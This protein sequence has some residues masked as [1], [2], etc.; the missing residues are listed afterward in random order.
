M[1]VTLKMEEM[2]QYKEDLDIARTCIF[3]MDKN[4]FLEKVI[5]ISLSENIESG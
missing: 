2:Y 3:S 4:E 5:F 1:D